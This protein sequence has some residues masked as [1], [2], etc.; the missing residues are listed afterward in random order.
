MRFTGIQD[1]W[2]RGYKWLRSGKGHSSLDRGFGDL[3]QEN[4][5][6]LNLCRSEFNV[7]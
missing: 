3:N 6:S 5:V 1:L 4:F 7:L 2:W